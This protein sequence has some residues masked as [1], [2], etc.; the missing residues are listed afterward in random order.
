MQYEKYEQRVAKIANL[1]KLM[2]KHRVLIISVLAFIMSGIVALLSTKGIITDVESCPAEIVYGENVEFDSKA[3]LSKTSFEY[4]PVGTDDWTDEMPKDP[5]E[6]YV[7]VV[8]DATFGNRYSEPQTFVVKPKKI[9][10]GIANGGEVVYGELPPVDAELVSNDVIACTAFTF[11]DRK[12]KAE[13][14]KDAIKIYD[15]DG[16]DITARYEI[17]TAAGYITTV[18][19]PLSV[20][21]GSASKVYD[22]LPL[23]NDE[24]NLTAGSLANG[25]SINLSFV[26]TI[27]SVGTQN[28][29]ANVQIKNEE[30]ID[31][32]EF[33][34]ITPISGILQVTGRPITV[35]TASAT[36]EYNGHYHGI[37]NY[38]IS[39]NTAVVEGHKVVVSGWK[40][41]IDVGNIKNEIELEVLDKNG[42]NVT[43][44]YEVSKEL[45]SIEITPRELNITTPSDSKVYDGTPLFN[46]D[47]TEIY[48]LVASDE[49]SVDGIL[50][51]GFTREGGQIPSI[52]DAGAIK[53]ELNFI[54]Y[55][56][57]RGDVTDNYTLKINYGTLTVSKRPLDVSSV[58]REL[59]YNGMEQSAGEV[60]VAA[61]SE[62]N[63]LVLSHTVSVVSSTNVKNVTTQEN[64]VAIDIYSGG[65]KVTDNYEISYEYGTIS[66]VPLIIVVQTATEERYY[67]GDALTSTDCTTVGNAIASGHSFQILDSSSITD[68]GEI[69]NEV[70]S[71]KIVDGE[72][73]DVTGNYRVSFSYGSLRVNK[74]PVSI[75]TESAE[76]EY[77]GTPLTADKWFDLYNSAGADTPGEMVNG[78]FPLVSGH[79][80]HANAPN[81]T[82]TDFGTS[83]NGYEG[84]IQI[85]DSDNR[86]VTGNYNIMETL[87]TLT[88][89]KRAITVS[90]D[91]IRLVYDGVGH[92]LDNVNII[93]GS[94]AGGQEL[95]SRNWATFKNVISNAYNEFGIDIKDINGISVVHNYEVEYVFGAVEID[96]RPIKVATGGI[97]EIYKGD[98]YSCGDFTYYV[99]N[100]DYLAICQ[101]HVAY[102]NGNAPMFIDVTD[103]SSNVFEV[104]IR[105][106]SEDVTA[107]YEISYDYGKVTIL[108]RP[109]KIT[110]PGYNG[111]YDGLE[112]YDYTVTVLDGETG[113][114]VLCNGHRIQIE[115]YRV[116]KNVSDTLD[117]VNRVTFK[118]LDG[119]GADVSDNYEVTSEYG[120]FHI[121]VRPVTLTGESYNGVYDGQ[122]HTLLRVEGQSLCT[123]HYAVNLNPLTVNGVT[124]QK[125]IFTADIYDENDNPVTENYEIT[126]VYG[127]AVV[128]KRHI[129]V[130][131]GSESK[132]YDGTR[133]VDL[134]YE[135]ENMVNGHYITL[136]TSYDI[137]D[138]G[139]ILNVFT[140]FAIY[141]AAKEDVTANYEVNI[142]WGTLEVT[143]RPVIITTGSREQVYNANPLTCKQWVETYD[144][145]YKL[146]GGHYVQGSITG[147]R[148]DVGESVNTYEGQIQIFDAY[149]TDVTSNYDLSVR[150]GT[151]KVTPRPITVVS[152]NYTGIYDA[153]EHYNNTVT[154]DTSGGNSYD[155]CGGHKIIVTEGWSVYKNVVSGADNIVPFIIVDENN[156]SVNLS[157]NYDITYVYGKITINPRPILVISNSAEFVY[158]AKPHTAPEGAS[159]VSDRNGYYKLCTGHKLQVQDNYLEFINVADSGENIIYVDIFEGEE[160]VSSNYD[161][162]YE[163]GTVDILPRTVYIESDSY[164][165]VYDG[166]EHII[167]GTT[168]I[169]ATEGA[170]DLCQGH[171]VSAYGFATFKDVTS[172]VYNTFSVK[173]LDGA[174]NDLSANYDINLIYGKVK[175]D[176]RKILISTSDYDAVYD[177]KE[178]N[179]DPEAVLEE[180]YYSICENQ[181]FVIIDRLIIKNVI[182]NAEN[183]VIIVINDE[184]N[185][186]VTDNYDIEYDYGKV[187]VRKRTVVVITESFDGEYDGREHSGRDY[188]FKIGQGLYAP[189]DY[190]V[191]IKNYSKFIDVVENASNVVDLEIVDIEGNSTLANYDI[192]YEYGKVTIRPR[193]VK[194]QTLNKTWEYDGAEHSFKKYDVLD[195]TSF[196]YGEDF[197][198]MSASVIV[199]VGEI[200][201]EFFEYDVYD[202]NYRNVTANY[203]I[204]IVSLG[205]LTVI[206]A[207][208]EDPDGP[209]DDGSGS[210][211]LDTSGSLG[212][213]GNGI[214]ISQAK[215]VYVVTTDTEG[216]IYLKLMSYGDFANGIWG[217]ATAYDQLIFDQ[218]AA[219]YLTSFALKQSGE[220]DSYITVTP[221][222]NQYLLPYYSLESSD[223]I[224]VDDTRV[225]GDAT[226]EYL[227]YY[228]SWDYDGKLMNV[229]EGLREFEEAYRKF[230]YEQYLG[231][232]EE[233]KAYL[234]EIIRTE[235]FDKNDPNIIEKVAEYIRK[236][237]V[238]NL[239]YDTEMDIADNPVIAFLDVY[240][241]GVC[242]HYATAA[243]LLYRAIGIPARYTIGYAVYA[244]A[245]E[246]TEVLSNQGHAW[247]EVY[248]DGLGWINVEVTGS[249]N[250]EDEKPTIIIEPAYQYKDYDGTPLVATDRLVEDEILSELLLN[251]YRY[252]IV[253]E[254][255]IENIGIG[256]SVI[257]SFVLYDP[258]GNDVTDMFNIETR[259]GK[260]E[261]CS[262]TIY[263]FLS[264]YSFIYDGTNRT[265]DASDYWKYKGGDDVELVIYAIN[266]SS[267]NA[268]KYRSE[269]INKNIT[270]YIDYK[271]FDADGN[272]VTSRY[273]LKVANYFDNDNDYDVFTIAKRQVEITT[274]SKT[275]KYNGKAL[276]LDSASITGGS[277]AKGHNYVIKCIGKAAAK[278]EENDNIYDVNS[279]KIVDAKG[280]DVTRNYD[281]EILLGKLKVT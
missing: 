190:A 71:Y 224:Q 280:N 220:R 124:E 265:F 177:G 182:E 32:T 206:E 56:P 63:G 201:N 1:F 161:I 21:T 212:G 248:I 134:S 86:D 127:T 259:E 164:D 16:N 152:G 136:I 131:T 41:I 158:D 132:V 257:T 245:D 264:Q 211:G 38:T 149:G 30:G 14:N 7:R 198:I 221:Y 172:K 91:E 82:R 208:K 97:E 129:N 116:F 138:V 29:L 50:G 222:V 179:V 22:G 185:R 278:G 167:S 268:C 122:N 253:V 4:A 187:T 40:Q 99:D 72:G 181:T 113:F 20:T 42:N 140:S 75:G 215:V 236:C 33:Y 256:T 106:G 196:V 57:E 274:G 110:T 150:E 53:N 228:F 96:P 239:E 3:F 78:V 100:V 101:G 44:N 81:G 226:D 237:A 266:I 112:H 199:D 267:T 231:V 83:T 195:G 103:S 271:I 249:S 178:H 263:I 189:C 90:S 275:Q 251:G 119:A 133:L 240:K 128:T 180:G 15:G 137:T 250:P 197:R 242:R 252:E 135:S 186:N 145:L 19:R 155:I 5:G 104:L 24:Y 70:F 154:V 270:A 157:Y 170:N 66:V 276:T 261:I 218:S 39:E 159:V 79:R 114:Y 12:N 238:Y 36:F 68:V 165:A 139:S 2:F 80:I 27:T 234:D 37:E 109:I 174:E 281:Y 241:E 151:L 11:N 64:V 214:D 17:T 123:G 193:H 232:D 188:E 108:P 223:N 227:L 272:D 89:T 58:S 168:V 55:N 46:T 194:I 156:T 52:T 76:K 125:H 230:V 255:M 115:D 162:T 260:L 93:S 6:Y 88:V 10:V 143:P 229:P 210:G 217:K 163:Y 59:T 142:T 144:S 225:T 8:A 51:G 48:G 61:G 69:N 203:V 65:R 258:D 130:V 13:A 184:N 147:S 98:Y 247:V 9:T 279:F 160:N 246:Q 153:T 121:S 117:P 191:L 102:I 243:T 18:P 43:H 54:I 118:I 171:Y 213:H 269:Q 23:T 244:N 205:T 126:Y 74:R 277:L 262:N 47:V 34:D 73:I 94:L 200:L 84:S 95:V 141:N 67:N 173:I 45:G 207:E 204:E 166:K 62:S 35:S 105:D 87:G 219:Y 202:V 273:N 107:N 233:T 209:G 31:V 254:G 216:V 192:R 49:L 85:L 146:V 92:V 176:V 26:G 28:N 235:K 111:V 175:I 120:E 25:D 77:D 169:T 148:T 183:R 60:T